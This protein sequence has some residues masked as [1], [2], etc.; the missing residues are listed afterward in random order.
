MNFAMEQEFF[1]DQKYTDEMNAAFWNSIFNIF[2][3]T[4]SLLYDLARVND[5]RRSFTNTAV[6]GE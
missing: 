2:E 5:E 4:M 1:Q 3:V 6:A